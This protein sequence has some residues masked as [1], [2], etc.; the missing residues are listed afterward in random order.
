MP[1][2]DDQPPE[3]RREA[4]EDPDG[5][6]TPERQNDPYTPPPA[7][8]DPFATAP[9]TPSPSPSPTNKP[10]P[11]PEPGSEPGSGPDQ[12]ERNEIYELAPDDTP[13]AQ[14]KRNTAPDQPVARPHADTP[15]H[16]EPTPPPPDDPHAAP[17]QHWATPPNTPLCWNCGYDLSG[18]AIDTKCPECGTPVWSRPPA[19]PT[20]PD[21]NR[22]MIWGIASLVASVACIGPIGIIPAAVA[23][24]YASKATARGV[25]NDG[26]LTTGKITAWV[27]IA[28]GG[29]MLV[30]LLIALAL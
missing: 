7:P 19:Q 14:S 4:Q 25:V 2:G 29:L 18:L 6:P 11:P 16:A 22:A 8:H 30:T 28:Y 24:T 23:L 5:T 9:F 12:P 21:A 27:T 15:Q 26:A 10:A 20:D 13:Q 17:A 3:D 1:K